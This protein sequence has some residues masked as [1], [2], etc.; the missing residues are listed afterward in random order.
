MNEKIKE[1]ALRSGFKEDRH[2]IYSPW[3]YGS[4]LDDELKEFAELIIKECSKV[5]KNG[6][7]WSG[8]PVGERKQC[9]L[10]EIA[11]MIEEHFG[12]KP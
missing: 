9:T 1:F 7:Y 11:K 6:G 4:P 2:G 3:V 5:I 10:P 8:G 12:I